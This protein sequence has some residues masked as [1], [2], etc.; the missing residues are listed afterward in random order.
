MAVKLRGN[1]VADVCANGHR[2]QLEAALT[3]LERKTSLLLHALTAMESAY[4]AEAP[5]D[6][7]TFRVAVEKVHNQIKRLRAECEQS[8]RS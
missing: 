1:V 3:D 5:V 8:E 7:E 2:V 4:A 6:L